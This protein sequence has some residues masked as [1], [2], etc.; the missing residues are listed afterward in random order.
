M[1]ETCIMEFRIQIQP[2]KISHMETATGK[3]TMIPFTG[4]VNSSLFQGEIL[5][6]AVDVQITNT[7]GVRHMCAR[8]MFQGTDSQGNPCRLFVDNN[9]YFENGHD[10]I[11][12]ETCPTFLTDSEILAPYLHQPRFA[13]KGFPTEQGVKIC[14]YDVK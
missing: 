11:P 12:F 14:I 6:G 10:P 5:P 1:K 2:D 4:S 7:A 9:G 3:V 8:Y 13:A